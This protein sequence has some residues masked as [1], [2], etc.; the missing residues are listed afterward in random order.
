LI[1]D[2]LESGSSRFERA[3]LTLTAIRAVHFTAAIQIVGALLFVCMMGRLPTLAA[4]SQ[5][6]ALLRASAVLAVIALAALAWVLGQ[7]ADMTGHTLRQAWNEGAVGLLLFKT[8]A[9]VVW[10]ARFGIAAAT[11]IVVW[12]LVCRRSL[13]SEATLFAAILLAIANFVSCAWLSHAASDGGP[14]GSLH[15]AAQALHMFAVSLWLGAL[16]PLAALVSR[17]F[18]RRDRS[19][20]AAVQAV[21]ISFGNIALLAVGII[22]ISGIS[23]TALVV[24][25]ATDLTTGNYAAL[26]ALK[27]VLFGFMLVVA[28]VKRFRLVPR[29][30]DSDHGSVAA[31]LWWTLPCRSDIGISG[32]NSRRCVGHHIARCRRIMPW[33]G[34]P[35]PLSS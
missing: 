7:A 25:D 2:H 6:R 15:L 24:G 3:V 32:P 14:Y 23:I 10:W 19:V 5:R 9:G 27:I 17:A 31:R 35:A 30:A 20:V 13:P 29:L 8:H 1:H 28:G 33:K 34:P 12:T 22:I 18:C 11:V 26:L 21:S 4:D 16:I